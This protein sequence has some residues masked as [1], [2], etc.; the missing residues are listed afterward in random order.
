MPR[1]HRPAKE[2]AAAETAKEAMKPETAVQPASTDRN[3]PELL[4]RASPVRSQPTQ[5]GPIPAR[6]AARRAASP[7]A[8]AAAT[9]GKR[10][11][12]AHVTAHV[13]ILSPS[14]PPH[15]LSPPRIARAPPE[16]LQRSAPPPPE[17]NGRDASR[18]HLE[19]GEA[20]P[21][22]SNDEMAELA[23]TRSR[24]ALVDSVNSEQ[25]SRITALEQKLRD[26]GLEL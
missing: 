21:K 18:L 26:G 5:P 25:A 15:A 16:S 7:H 22:K 2:A 17:S 13:G 6:A 4:H 8:A 19:K 14:T 1:L 20:P 9:N 23:A 3:A 11:P 12:P 24:M 10:S